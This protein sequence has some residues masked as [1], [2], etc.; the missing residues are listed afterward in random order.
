MQL[1]PT[2]LA[3]PGQKKKE[4]MKIIPKEPKIK[5]EKDVSDKLADVSISESGNTANKVSREAPTQP[6]LKPLKSLEGSLFERLI[7]IHGNSIKCLLSVQYRMHDMIMK[8]PSEAMYNSKLTAYEAVSK[9]TLLELPNVANN[10]ADKDEVELSSPLVF[11]DTDGYDFFE[12]ID[13]EELKK[14][15]VEEGSKYNENEVEIIKRKVQ[16]LVHVGVLDSQI[17]IITPYQAQVGHLSNAIKPQFPG[18]EIGSVDG[19]QGR[20]QEVVIMSLVRSN[21]TVSEA[22]FINCINISQIG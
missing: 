3:R 7:G 6:T 17:A 22:M 14:G 16:D 10:N 20:E 12:R 2:V 9:R 11:I 13:S 15:A 21:E 1:P 4:R 18:C 8:Y 5:K 19:V